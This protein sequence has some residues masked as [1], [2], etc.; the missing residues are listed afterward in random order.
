MKTLE[1]KNK[2]GATALQ[3]SMSGLREAD[4]FSKALYLIEAGADDSVEY[5]CGAMRWPMG[6][7]I[8][9]VIDKWVNRLPE[10]Y[11]CSGHK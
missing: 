3:T 11:D 1:V 7:S 2:F 8:R 5:L 4:D 10:Q 9:Q 6:M